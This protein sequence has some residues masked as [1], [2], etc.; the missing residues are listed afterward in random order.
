MGSNICITLSTQVRQ[1]EV[2]PVDGLASPIWGPAQ[3]D[4]PG[5]EVI[6][7]EGDTLDFDCE[8]R[9]K[10]VRES[11]EPWRKACGSR[12]R[13]QRREQWGASTDRTEVR[14]G[15]AWRESWAAAELLPPEAEVGQRNYF[16]GFFAKLCVMD[17]ERG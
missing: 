11:P 1:W 7:Y 17:F 4:D 16:R 10:V 8:L 5:K 2:G 3:G 15:K 14:L 6:G 9:Y 12:G 13:A